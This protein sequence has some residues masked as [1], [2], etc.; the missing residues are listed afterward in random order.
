MV[1]KLAHYDRKQLI[2]MLTRQ[3]LPE[4]TARSQEKAMSTSK[5]SHL[6]VDHHTSL[7]KKMRE[8]E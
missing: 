1:E 4:S 8:L 6:E 2:S 3:P 5:A 7:P